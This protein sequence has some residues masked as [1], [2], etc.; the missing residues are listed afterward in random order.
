MTTFVVRRLIVT[1]PVVLLVG[2]AAFLLVNLTPGDPADFFLDPDSPAEEV[3]RVRERLGLDQP[4]PVQFVR[5][6]GG[7]LRGDL[8]NSFHEKR[9]VIDMFARAFPPTIYLTLTSL[10]L[11][12]VLAVPIGIFSAIRQNSVLDRFA[13]VF[14]LIGVATPNFW[15]GLLLIQLFAVNLGWLPAQGFVR[16]EQGWW[17]SLRTLILPSIA[18]GYSGAAL[19]ARMTRSGMLEVLRQDYVRTARA[20]GI[21]ENR[22]NYV[23]A[24]RNAFNPILTVIGLAVTSL[25]SGSLVVELV[26]NFPGVGRLVVDSVFRRDYPVIQGSLL[27]IAGITI[28]V[29]L[30]VDL[31]YAVTDP[32]IRYG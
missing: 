12:V 20:K 3:V 32:R 16:P 21:A 2:I 26:F 19:I 11:A 7:V 31:L 8:G 9:P 4:L 13:T 23:H 28:V 25:I 30:V 29:N 10:F 24:L 1:I 22:V 5:W 15:L 18:L 14:V 17:P 6:F 27:L